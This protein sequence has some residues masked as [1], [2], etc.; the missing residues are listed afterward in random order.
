M[1]ENGNGNG[2][3]QR[4][5]TVIQTV[6]VV[7]MFIAGFWAGVIN[8]LGA[9]ID[10]VETGAVLVAE[11]REYHARLDASITHLEADLN[12]LR[13]SQVTRGEHMQKWA[14]DEAVISNMQRQIDDL[15]KEL[16]SSFS[17]GDKIKEL[18]TQVDDLRRPR[19]GK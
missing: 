16:G 15:K 1:T 12:K 6:S 4:Y 8:P 3:S 9:R 14:S 5:N 11:Y 18:Q 2:F 13:E 19:E 7:A 10:R 17:L